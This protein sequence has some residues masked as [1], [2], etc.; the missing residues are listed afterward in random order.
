MQLKENNEDSLKIQFEWIK[1]WNLIIR[2]FLST[3]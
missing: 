2:S 1:F 3:V